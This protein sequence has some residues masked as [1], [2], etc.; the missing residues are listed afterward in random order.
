MQKSRV[1]V[2]AVAVDTS[3]LSAEQLAFLERK[4]SES[5]SPAPAVSASIHPAGRHV[6]AVLARFCY[7]LLL[8]WLDRMYSV[9]GWAGL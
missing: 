5:H 1:I 4:R 8:T 6:S 2:T 3:R 9:G 7:V